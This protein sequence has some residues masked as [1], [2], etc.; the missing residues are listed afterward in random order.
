MVCLSGVSVFVTLSS[1]IFQNVELF[2]CLKKVLA[3][4]YL[5]DLRR[6]CVCV[7]VMAKNQD[8]LSHTGLSTARVLFREIRQSFFQEVTSSCRVCPEEICVSLSIRKGFPIFLPVEEEVEGHWPVMRF[9]SCPFFP[10]ILRK[11]P[12]SALPETVGFSL[13]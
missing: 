9:N 11:S 3:Y 4:I 8:S 7:C 10:G 13:Q 6:I 2:L 1:H 12:L 5:Q